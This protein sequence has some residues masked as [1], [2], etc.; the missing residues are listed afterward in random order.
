MLKNISIYLI[1]LILF[2]CSKDDESSK[3][4]QKITDLGTVPVELASQP[5]YQLVEVHNSEVFV[6]TKSG[7]WKK[8]IFN[9]TPWISAGLENMQV[10]TLI[11]DSDNSSRFFAG[12]DYG[13]ENS[14]PFYYSSNGGKTWEQSQSSPFNEWE[15]KYEPFYNLTIRPNSPDIIYANMSGTSISV[16]VDGGKSWRLANRATETN[17]GYPSLIHFMPNTPDA[18]YQGSEAVLDQATVGRY[19]IDKNDPTMIGESDVF[20]GENY[21]LENRRPNCM[22]SSVGNPDV[23]YLGL[24]GALIKTDG[25]DWTYIFKSDEES[26]Y[27]YAYIKGI[28]VNP[29]NTSHIIFGGG[30]NGINESLSLFETTDEGKTIKEIELGITFED[31]DVLS[32]MP[33]DAESGALA[34]LI[35]ENKEGVKK[36]RVIIYSIN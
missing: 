7:V 1:A 18:L 6:G 24:E 35:S 20:I 28:W 26:K 5:T 14:V 30:V 31:P 12:G 8:H 27:P 22:Y 9:K 13:K 2:G 25:K 32:I 10:Y 16:S 19:T 36:L 17:F 33:I 11:N 23:M 3:L 15:E 21:E 29:M 34:I 4:E